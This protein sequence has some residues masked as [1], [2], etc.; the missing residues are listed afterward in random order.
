M[1]ENFQFKKK[2][3]QNFLIDQ[4]KI[5]EIISKSEMNKD[6]LVIEIGP[7]AGALTAHLAEKSKQVI[8][9]EID[10]D[11]KE[12]L[13]KI[14]EAH[15]NL[16]VIYQDF[17]TVNLKDAIKDYDYQKLYIVSN[18]P[19]YITTPIIEKI[20]KEKLSVSKMVLMMQKEAGERF[21]KTSGEKEYNAIHV[22]LSYYYHLSKLTMVSRSCFYPVPNVDSVV[23]L[24]EEKTEK[25]FL[26]N[27]DLFVELVQTAFLHKRK[28]LRNNLKK[29][30]L[31]RLEKGGFDLSKRAEQLSLEEFVQMANYLSEK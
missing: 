5:K 20:V 28:N 26:Q 13:S 18:L 2:Y 3:G 15:S 23:L 4:N 24:L 31:E 7:G 17:L 27:E 10:T 11:L 14:E 22:L 12:I 21:L 6:T 29:Y 9:Y 19:Y 16:K 25:L 8:A 30:D 1:I